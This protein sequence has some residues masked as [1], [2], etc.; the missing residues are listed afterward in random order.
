MIRPPAIIH[1]IEDNRDNPCALRG[2]LCCLCH[3]ISHLTACF[4]PLIIY[5]PFA[6]FFMRWPLRL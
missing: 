3:V 6:G 2:C 4:L 5:R 1:L